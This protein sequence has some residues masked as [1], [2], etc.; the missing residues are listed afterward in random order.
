MAELHSPQLRATITPKVT[1]PLTGGA[2]G[3]AFGAPVEDLDGRGYSFQE[4]LIEGVARS[5][6]AAAGHAPGRDGLWAAEPG[7]TAAYK[8]RIMVA[9]PIDPSKFN[10][11]ALLNWQ[12]VTADFDIGYPSGEELFGGCAWVGVTAQRI[13][14]HGMQGVTKSLA[15]WDPQRYVD[16]H[17][18]GDAFSYDIFAQVGRLLKGAPGVGVDPL[19]GLRPEVLLAMGGSQSAMRLGSYINAAQPHDK[20]FDGFLLSAHWGICPPVVETPLST[21]FAPLDAGVLTGTSQIADR[22]DAPIM[23]LAGETEA[24]ANF[25]ARQPD[26]ETFR[27]WE[28]AGVAHSDPAQAATMAAIADRDGMPFAAAP[29]PRNVLEWG[30]L[31]DAALRHLIR[32]VREGIAPPRFPLIDIVQGPNGG[33]I[34]RDELGN[35]L[36]GIRLPDLAVA[37][38]IHLGTNVNDPT[39][40]TS[41]E[42]RMFDLD[43]MLDLHD[44]PEDFL[45]AWDGAV[46]DLVDGGLASPDA[47]ANLR[48]RGWVVW[49]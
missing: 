17:H 39:Y 34:Q 32:W 21:Q 5:Y 6:R 16:L 2:H 40:A 9:R 27:F 29:P 15:A 38:G 4:F 7:D 20:L 45:M 23:V 30:F 24:L 19:D 11:V 48:R 12:N 47:A 25:P 43:R 31:R 8:T 26:T 10:G 46:Q 22:G 3:W 41:G 13:G 33:M 49:P 14:V 18:P 44:E 42:S 37:T 36:G 35:A 28:V 1:G